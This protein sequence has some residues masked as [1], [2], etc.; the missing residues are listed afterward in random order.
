MHRTPAGKQRV[1]PILRRQRAPKAQVR[2]MAGSFICS[3][4]GSSGNDLKAAA[5]TPLRET[6]ASRAGSASQLTLTIEEILPRAT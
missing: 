6:Q 4:T 1:G 3:T 5:A 2:L